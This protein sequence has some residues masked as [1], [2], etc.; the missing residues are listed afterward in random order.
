MIVILLHDQLRGKHVVHPAGDIGQLIVGAFTGDGVH[1][2]RTLDIVTAEQADGLDNA[3]GDPVGVALLVDLKLRRAKDKGR[4]V[5]AQVALDVAVKGLREGVFHALLQPDHRGL[6]GDHVHPHIG[7]Q[8]GT[9]IGKPFEQVGV[10]NGSHPDRPALVV[11]LGGVK[12]ILKLADHIAEG[13]HLPVAEVLGGGLVQGGDLVEG[14]LGDVSGKVA[15]LHGQQI[16]VGP[17]PED[18]QGNEGAHDADGDEN[19][20]QDTGGQTAGFDEAQVV[21]GTAAAPDHIHTGG[22]EGG[23]HKHD[24]EHGDKDIKIA[25]LGIDGGQSHIKIDQTDQNGE[26]DTEHQFSGLAFWPVGLFGRL[27]FHERFSFRQFRHFFRPGK[28]LTKV[29]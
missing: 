17:G 22:E 15:V 7:G 27:L 23:D 6:L 10:G 29:V 3:G 18:R 25:G 20:Q 19:Q 4:V 14:D 24:A 5:E 21:L 28:G 13:A 26:Y 9:S 8:T 16:S 1:Q 12:G 11:D 2:H